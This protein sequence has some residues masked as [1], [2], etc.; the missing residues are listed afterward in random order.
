MAFLAGG[1]LHPWTWLLTGLALALSHLGSLW[2]SPAGVG[3]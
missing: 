1:G 2:I 3:G